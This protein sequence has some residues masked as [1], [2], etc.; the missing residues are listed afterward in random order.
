VRDRLAEELETIIRGSEW[1]MAVLE[2]ARDVK[3]PDWWI[4]AGALRDLVWDELHGGFEPG[5]VRDVDVAFFDATDLSSAAESALE[6]RLCERLPG[7]P[8]EAKNQAAVHTWYAR[9]FG[10]EVEPLRSAAEGVSTWPETATAVGV[11]LLGNEEIELTAWW[12]WPTSSRASAAATRG[13][14]VSKSSSAASRPR[15]SAPAGPGCASSLT[16]IS[17]LADL[18]RDQRLGEIRI[19]SLADSRSRVRLTV[20]TVGGCKEPRR[21]RLPRPARSVTAVSGPPAKG[22]PPFQTTTRPGGV[23][24]ENTA[25]VGAWERW[26][27]IDPQRRRDEAV[28][29]PDASSPAMCAQ[30]ALN[31]LADQSGVDAGHVNP[32]AQGYDQ[33]FQQW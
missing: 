23:G 14:S 15:T 25:A 2:A 16:E 32:V 31:R 24:G 9:R 19:I 10:F 29:P 20:V 5:M 1:F 22:L 26:V 28:N 6:H 30:P 18:E 21:L 27:L 4:G 17:P 11:R 3:P 12:A 33:P 7:V 8:W 13:A